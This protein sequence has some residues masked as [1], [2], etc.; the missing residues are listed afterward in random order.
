MDAIKKEPKNLAIIDKIKTD[1]DKTVTKYNCDICKLIQD[2]PCCHLNNHNA[3]NVCDCCDIKR[4]PAC[5]IRKD[6]DKPETP[7]KKWEYEKICEKHGVDPYG[8]GGIYWC[9]TD[10]VP[11]FLFHDIKR[12]KYTICVAGNPE[13]YATYQRFIHTFENDNKQAAIDY[14]TDFRLN[15]DN[16]IIEVNG[17]TK[18]DDELD[19]ACK[20]YN[21]IENEG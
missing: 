3:T 7:M 11:V 19:E 17:R 20:K 4:K 9:I 15:W 21:I 10:Q 8:H 2:T 1:I 12:K 6:I 14:I 5:C 13:K 18:E 16:R